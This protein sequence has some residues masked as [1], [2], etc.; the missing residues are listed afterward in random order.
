MSANHQPFDYLLCILSQT[1]GPVGRPLADAP[2]VT[3]S[4]TLVF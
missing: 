2:P 3:T 4:M 1:I